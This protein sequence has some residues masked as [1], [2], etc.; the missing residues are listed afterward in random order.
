MSDTARVRF[1]TLQTRHL[2]FVRYH[3]LSQIRPGKIAR[4]DSGSVIDRRGGE[5]EVDEHL[6]GIFADRS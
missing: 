4:L 3:A 1:I 2:A 6:F 5:T